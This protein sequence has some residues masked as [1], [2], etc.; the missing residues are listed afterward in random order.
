MQ[1]TQQH[2][3]GAVART[4]I[5]QDLPPVCSSHEFI[6]KTLSQLV[7]T[8][9]DGFGKINGTLTE[10]RVE[11]AA[12]EASVGE[13]LKGAWHEIR[14]IGE[15]LDDVER[16]IPDAIAAHAANCDLNDITEVGLKTQLRKSPRYD[17]P[18]GSSRPSVVGRARVS[19]RTQ[20]WIAVGIGVVVLAAGVWIGAK[21]VSGSTRDANQAVRDVAGVVR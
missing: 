16:A 21:V 11:A 2:G 10:M 12:R 6:E 18:V 1:G 8:T 5:S 13:S 4:S 7:K 20:F 17:T 14:K 15:K 19:A 3:E 9:N